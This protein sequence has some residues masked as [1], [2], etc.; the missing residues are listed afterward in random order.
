MAIMQTD[1]GAV[2][3]LTSYF[4]K[5]QPAGGNNLTLCLFVNDMTPSDTNT[6]ASF[7]EPTGGGYATKTLTAG[8]WTVTT[9]GGI[10]QAAYAQQTFTFT[11]A[12]DGAASIYGYFVK[13]ADGEVIFAERATASWAPVENGDTYKITVIYQ[14]SKGTPT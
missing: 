14:L 3:I 2:Q 8:S 1:E 6:S 9:T 10:S 13:D 12:L 5:S 11:G 7:T 4:N